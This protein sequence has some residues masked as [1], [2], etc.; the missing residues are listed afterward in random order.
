MLVLGRSVGQKVLLSGNITVTV[1]GIDGRGR[2]RL[3][4]DAPSCISILR[5]EAR[6]RTREGRK[7]IVDR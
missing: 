1:V 5:P 6:R 3:G 7:R 4:F 2:V